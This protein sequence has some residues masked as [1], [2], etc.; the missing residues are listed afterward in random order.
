MPTTSPRHRKHQQ[1]KP[2]N[3]LDKALIGLIVLLLVAMIV[4]LTIFE[5]YKLYILLVGGGML[6][7]NL[8]FVGY[9]ARRNRL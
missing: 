8:L 1:R 2:L 3:G 5:G 6:I 4:V 9:F 7:L